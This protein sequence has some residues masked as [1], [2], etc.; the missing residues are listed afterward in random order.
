MMHPELPVRPEHAKRR[1]GGEIIQHPSNGT[2]NLSNDRFGCIGLDDIFA[3]HEVVSR[4][5]L[6]I[7]P[8]HSDRPRSDVSRVDNERTECEFGVPKRTGPF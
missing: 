4:K 8:A 2:E 5:Y 3:A 1:S 7:W 6:P